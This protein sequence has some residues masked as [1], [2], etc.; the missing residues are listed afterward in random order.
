ME[1]KKISVFAE[2]NQGKEFP[3]LSVRIIYW[4]LYWLW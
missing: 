2:S 3:I 4:T 1:M